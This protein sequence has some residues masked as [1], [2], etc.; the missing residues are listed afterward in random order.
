MSSMEF[1]SPFEIDLV[2]YL[3]FFNAKANSRSSHV[4]VHNN[5]LIK[6]LGFLTGIGFMTVLTH[7]DYAK[8]LDT[9][10]KQ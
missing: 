10:K 7:N 1:M 8:E 3:T 4:F 9:I 5:L 6:D 2:K